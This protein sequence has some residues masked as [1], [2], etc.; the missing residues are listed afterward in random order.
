MGNKHDK[1]GGAAFATSLTENGHQPGMTLRD[2]FA[3]QALVG[4]YAN[5]DFGADNEPYIK[6]ARWAYKQADAM[7]KARDETETDQCKS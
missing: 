5:P 1:E 3:G 2:Y 7:I 4:M 6:N